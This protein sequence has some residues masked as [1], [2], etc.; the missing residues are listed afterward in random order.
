[1]TGGYGVQITKYFKYAPAY[2][3]A[4]MSQTLALVGNVLISTLTIIILW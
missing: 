3:P 2:A 1:M 4:S